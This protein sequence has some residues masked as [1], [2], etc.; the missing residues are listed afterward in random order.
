MLW[1][2]FGISL[3]SSGRKALANFNSSM[4]EKVT[5]EFHTYIKK[6]AITLEFG[7]LIIGLEKIDYLQ[8]E[9][10]D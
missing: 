6:K 1:G 5:V 4:K 8:N 2:L 7:L 9:L 10:R 3:N